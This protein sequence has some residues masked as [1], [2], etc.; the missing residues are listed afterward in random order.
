MAKRV[1]IFGKQN[2][3]KCAA[4]KS[5][6]DHFLVKMGMIGDVQAVFFD[7]DSE[8]GLA[9]GAFRDVLEVPTTIIDN[10]EEDV[11]R[12]TAMI[13]DSTELQNALRAE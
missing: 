7:M 1:S 8:E 13:P 4:T 10:G 2:C 9:E 12:W 5:K 3:G 11:A 6:V